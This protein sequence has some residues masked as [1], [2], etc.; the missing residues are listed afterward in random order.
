MAAGRERKKAKKTVA[1]AKTV[2]KSKAPANKVAK[3]AV[4]KTS[5]VTSPSKAEAR[6]PNPTVKDLLPRDEPGFISNHPLLEW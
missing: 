5:T 2:K 1:K 6:A 3:H 4:K